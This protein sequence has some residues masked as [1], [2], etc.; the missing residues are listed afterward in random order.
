MV[1]EPV[2]VLKHIEPPDSP[3]HPSLSMFPLLYSLTK[4]VQFISSWPPPPGYI[5]FIISSVTNLFHEFVFQTDD[6]GYFSVSK[7]GQVQDGQLSKPVTS[8]LLC[9]ELASQ[10]CNTYIPTV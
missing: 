2:H 9:N 7:P 6:L 5:L 4:E 3:L 8:A 10:L 1:P